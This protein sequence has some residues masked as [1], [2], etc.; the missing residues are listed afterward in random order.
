LIADAYFQIQ[1]TVDGEPK[2]SAFFLELERANKSSRVMESKL[3]RYADFYYSGTYEAS[4]GTRALRVL[5]VFSDELGLRS[6]PRIEQG[7]KTAERLGI[8]LARFTGLGTVKV[9][10]PS[11]LLNSAMWW[12]PGNS[13]PVPLFLAPAEA[14]GNH[15]EQK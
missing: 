4:F 7:L 15:N 11:E 13:T 2:T 10:S 9:G 8:T 3:R 6:Q 5:V 12:Q 14:E 1:R